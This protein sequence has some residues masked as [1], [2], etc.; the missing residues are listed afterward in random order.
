[1][2]ALRSYVRDLAL[3]AT[4]GEARLAPPSADQA[5]WLFDHVLFGDGRRGGVRRVE[6]ETAR[7]K[8]RVSCSATYRVLFEDGSSEVCALKT[9]ANGKAAELAARRFAHEHAA[10]F[11]VLP[12]RSL[13]MWT[14][15]GDRELPGLERI[16]DRRQIAR[17]VEESGCVPARSV[18]RRRTQVEFLRYKPERRAIACVDLSLRG[19]E[20]GLLRFAARFHP[21]AR[22][23]RIVAARRAFESVRPNAALRL[24]FDVP[25]AGALF[26]PW[27]DIED[28]APTDFSHAGE[29]GELLGSLHA[30]ELPEGLE[31]RRPNDPADARMLF[32]VDTEL[33]KRFDAWLATR[34]AFAP[35]RTTWSHG[36]VHPDQLA[37][38]RTGEGKGAWTLMDLDE[39]APGDPTADLASWIADRLWEEPWT[40]FDEAG[41]TLLEG[42][43]VLPCERTRLEVTS[44]DALVAR[45]AAAI[46]RLQSGAIEAAHLAFDS[47]EREF[48]T[49]RRR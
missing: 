7:W 38:L 19:T 13:A 31:P 21:P 32:S 11:A 34:P 25:H 39:L 6:L 12:E 2:T 49:G 20:P 1:M 35:T 26:E 43:G 8:P 36:D 17:W 27:L 44:A 29:A 28:Q 24:A 45:A 15:M 48:Q 23:A 30:L 42:Y 3:P 14:V 10:N 9:Y 37:R 47:I 5:C 41:R 40:T 18:R 16:L 22:A 33:L 4:L 46:R